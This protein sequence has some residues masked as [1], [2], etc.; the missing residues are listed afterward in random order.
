MW[1]KRLIWLWFE[2][3]LKLAETGSLKQD[4]NHQIPLHKCLFFAVTKWD[5][6]II[7]SMTDKPVMLQR[8]YCTCISVCTA[9]IGEPCFVYRYVFLFITIISF[10]S[11]TRHL[12]DLWSPSALIRRSTLSKELHLNWS[13]VCKIPPT[14]TQELLDYR[15]CNR[16]LSLADLWSN[17]M[18]FFL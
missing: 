2:I 12:I 7:Y 11:E 9:L 15:F 1:V 4:Q 3:I 18:L 6:A 14:K 13:W 16:T 17:P 8:A 10:S 5:I